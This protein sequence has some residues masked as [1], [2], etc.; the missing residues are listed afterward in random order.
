MSKAAVAETLGK[1]AVKKGRPALRK[2]VELIQENEEEIR[3]AHKI[4]KETGAYEKMLEKALNDTDSGEDIRNIL[5]KFES[6]EMKELHELEIG[7]QEI[8]SIIQNEEQVYEYIER[9]ISIIAS[10]EQSHEA[11]EK[12]IDAHLKRFRE[13][14]DAEHLETAFEEEIDAIKTLHEEAELATE[15]AEV[16]E[17]AIQQ[18]V[19]IEELEE[20][21][22]DEA[23]EQEKIF[24]NEKGVF[25]KAGEQDF[26][27]EV[28]S[29]QH[30]EHDQVSTEKQ[31]TEKVVKMGENELNQ[32]RDELARMMEEA[33]TDKKD[34]GRILSYYK[35]SM[36]FQ[37]GDRFVQRLEEAEEMLE[38]DIKS[39][40]GALNML[41][42]NNPFG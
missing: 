23:A 26:L 35:D 12:D 28:Q 7:I 9:V 32:L 30:Q 1:Q 27:Q 17:R 11:E 34:V 39:I 42:N 29:E 40:E 22:A 20:I 21:E 31:E 15:A 13:T 6:L 19:E 5:D 16:I 8:Q 37:K 24:E 25:V 10:V 38:Q 14:R 33:K 18:T 36:G 2:S 3:K 4:L 41:R